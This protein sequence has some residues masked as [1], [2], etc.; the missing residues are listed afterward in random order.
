MAMFPCGSCN[1]P[2]RWNQAAIQCDI[3]SKWLH[4]SCI[5][6]SKA[7]YAVLQSSEDGWCCDFCYRSALPFVD[8][9]SIFSTSTQSSCSA[10]TS[11]PSAAKLK[12]ASHAGITV[13]YTNCRSLLPKVDELRLLAGSSTPGIIAITESWLDS[14]IAASEVAIPSY[15][16]YRRDRSRHG[17]GICLYISDSISISRKSCHESI[18]FMHVEVTVDKGV[19]FVGLYYRPP[20]SDSDFSQLETLLG[21]L[22][23][24]KYFRVLILG[25]FNVDLCQADSP[26][27]TDLLGL[28]ATVGLTQVVDSPTRFSASTS[29]LLDHVY[30]SDV[31]LVSSHSLLP[32]L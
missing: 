2:V 23:L 29:S 32:P 6:V 31:S 28:A 1:L 4:T 18:E 20:G 30:V 21:S 12:G 19:L 22:D 24:A 3:C 7:E 16:L 15:Q 14:T 5:G 11:M 26:P 13:F 9:S 8:C 17:G 27:A 10:D 25:D